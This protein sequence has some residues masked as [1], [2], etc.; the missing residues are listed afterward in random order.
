M[1]TGANKAKA[2]AKA[3]AGDPDP[4]CPASALQH[5]PDVVVLLGRATA[6]A[7]GVRVPA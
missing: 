1:A 2:V 6:C 4:S 3:L 5:H 7:L